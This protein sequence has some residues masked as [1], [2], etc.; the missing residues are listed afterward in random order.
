MGNKRKLG[1]D[2]IKDISEAIEKHKLVAQLL[3][4]IELTEH[5]Q[6]KITGKLMVKDISE[7]N[8]SLD[9]TR[10]I[11]KAVTDA[12]EKFI[13]LMNPA[14]KSVTPE[15]AFVFM[16]DA[17]SEIFYQFIVANTKKIPDLSQED[18][19]DLM[20]KFYGIIYKKVFRQLDIEG[21]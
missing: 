8:A 3:D 9:K 5:E 19:L 6:K 18:L 17:A 10:Y 13:E 20:P 7:L 4:G 11:G 1:A 14:M 2:K 15:M 12:R 21:G 16:V